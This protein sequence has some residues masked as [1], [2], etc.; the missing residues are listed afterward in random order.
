MR[1]ATGVSEP[2]DESASDSATVGFPETP[3]PLA[4]VI[5]VPLAAT[6]R[7]T[8]LEPEARTKMPLVER[9]WSESACPVSATPPALLTASPVPTATEIVLPLLA[10]P[11]PSVI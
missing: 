6:E 4:T 9:L 7:A 1:S 2:T 8:T 10:M 5:P 11:S 3:S